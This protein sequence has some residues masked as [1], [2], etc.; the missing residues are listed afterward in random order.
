ML[1]PGEIVEEELKSEG[2]GFKSQMAHQN[3][4]EIKHFS[5]AIE[6]D[7]HRLCE[8]MQLE[9]AVQYMHAQDNGVFNRGSRIGGLPSSRS[10]DLVFRRGTEPSRHSCKA[11]RTSSEKGLSI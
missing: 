5:V 7:K 3:F 8:S 11:L 1:F 10:T 2:L 6:T 9:C 4:N